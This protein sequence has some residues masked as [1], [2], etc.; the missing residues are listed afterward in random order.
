M[1]IGNIY[2]SASG[3]SKRVADYYASKLN[4]QSFDFTPASIRQT[5]D[6]SQTFDLILLTFPVHCQNIPIPLKPVLPKLQAKYFI[7]NITYGKMSFG[8]CLE[9]AKKLLGGKVIGA[10]LIPAKHTYL[11][12]RSID[13]LSPLDEMIERIPLKQE[14]KIPRFKRHPLAN[15]FPVIRSQLG[16]KITCSDR[17]TG[18]NVCTEHCPTESISAGTI[19]KH[20]CIRCLKC[21]YVCPEQALDFNVRKPLKYYLRKERE[22]LFL[23]F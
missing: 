17:C 20:K 19:K 3:E 2:F 1:M 15:F 14:I 5:F 11:N 23:I 10:S 9:D 4:C 21:I 6:Y 16:I 18:C 8:N 12:E 7:I 13:N 22:N